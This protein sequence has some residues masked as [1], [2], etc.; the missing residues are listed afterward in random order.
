MFKPLMIIMK[1]KVYNVKVSEN[2]IISMFKRFTD[3][4]EKQGRFAL[5]NPKKRDFII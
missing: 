4:W 5:I 1:D 3:I 2:T